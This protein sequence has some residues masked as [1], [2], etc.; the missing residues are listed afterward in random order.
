MAKTHVIFSAGHRN[1]TG[2]GSAGEAALT[3]AYA[4]AYARILPEKGFTVQY[5]QRLKPAKG[6]PD[7]YAGGL[8]DVA[9]K[10]ASIAESL[11]ANAP[12][13]M[14][15]VHMESPNAGK[16]IFAIRPGRRRARRHARQ[17]ARQLGQQQEDAEAGAA[18]RG[19]DQQGDRDPHALLA[20]AGADLREADGSWYPPPSTATRA[21]GSPWTG[22]AF[23]RRGRC[24]SLPAIGEGWL[25]RECVGYLFVR[26]LAVSCG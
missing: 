5:V 26:L 8:G 13:V 10:V 16:G 7:W 3:L 21:G 23:R 4:D 17:L 18:D 24:R 2:G 1:K 15:D 22:R 14:I 19:G 6:K 25:V 20:R 9:K 12:V 11:P